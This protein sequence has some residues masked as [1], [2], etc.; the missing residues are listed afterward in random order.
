MKRRQLLLGGMAGAMACGPTWPTSPPAAL[1]VCAWTDGDVFVGA[2]D[3]RLHTLQLALAPGVA[4]APSR[5]GLWVALQGGAVERWERA[6]SGGAPRWHA[7]ERHPFD[8]PVHAI[9]ASEDGA[10][11]LVAHGERI[12][13]IESGRGVL[14]RLDGR[15]LDGRLRGRAVTLLAV[16]QRRS[17]VASLPALDELWEISLDPQ[18]PPIFDG[19][20]HDY[21]MGESLPSA[22]YLGARR[23]PMQRPVPEIVYSDRRVHWIAGRVAS[24][25][26]VVHLDVR[27]Q[28]AL[29]P[30]PAA[31]PER[32][33]LLGEPGAW[34]WW[35]PAGDGVHCID[36]TR[37]VQLEV[38]PVADAPAPVR[39]LHTLADAPWVE[40]AS[41]WRV[42]AARPGELQVLDAQGQVLQRWPLP[43]GSAARGVRWMP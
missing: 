41:P 14:K 5:A 23:M 7:A 32:A 12:T 36:A 29:L 11:V 35:V 39:L 37:W 28:I 31:R 40:A 38:V 4:P 2:A 8:E 15:T 13:V 9:A 10:H 34:R 25:V 26:A 17:V 3:G 24:G 43:A 42:A 16:P 21:R 33:L 18:A 1:V 30:M 27:R 22:G 19:L 20:V 6:V